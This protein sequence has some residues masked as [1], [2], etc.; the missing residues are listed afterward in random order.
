M[1]TLTNSFEGGTAGNT[2]TVAGSDGASGDAW[3][4]TT[5]GTGSTCVYSAT[6]QAHGS[7]CMQVT[8][9]ATNTTE[10]RGWTVNAGDSAADQWF[11]FYVDP[12][13]LTGT[14]SP[15]RGQ[16][17][18][19]NA[20]RFRIQVT[21]AGQVTLRNSANTTVWTSS[22]NLTA[23]TQWRI[24]CRVAGSTTGAARVWVYSG[25]STTAAQDS[26]E[27]S[28][29][30]GG[31]I[32]EVWWGQ[33][34]NGTNIA[35]KFDDV[36]WSDTGA[37][38]PANATAAGAADLSAA[39][40]LAA[41]GVRVVSG[42][43][44]L[45]A[46]STLTA[47]GAAISPASVM[48]S[49]ASA[50]TS[51]AFGVTSGAAALT[52][53]SGLSATPTRMTAGAAALTAT[54]TVS[55]TTSRTAPA[56]AP[57]TAVSVLTGDGTGVANTQVTLTADTALAIGGTHTVAAEAVLSATASFTAGTTYT[58]AAS[59]VLAASS[60]L[61]AAAATEQPKPARGRLR[62]PSTSSVH[63]PPRSEVRVL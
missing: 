24:E 4:L 16:N 60:S 29:D 49:A 5:S 11:R 44:P 2:I 38:G 15:L 34:A 58:H 12:A 61:T 25:D 19:S 13:N 36:G 47:S 28:G 54:A 55:A 48:L 3:T 37:L 57:L 63:T 53:E 32:R 6:G 17:A 56:G 39:S 8:T 62:F 21:A 52:A 30:F 23:G 40:S 27:L 31:T 42:A 7:L 45:S 18:G 46:A 9:G 35:V 22:P 20:Q 43:A 50:L 14:V 1:T 26:G 59:A 33:T 41:P 10:R 51:G